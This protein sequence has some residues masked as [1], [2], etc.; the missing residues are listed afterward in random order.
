MIG[1]GG[2]VL[3]QHGKLMVIW[4]YY[5]VEMVCVWGGACECVHAHMC[6]LVC[7]CVRAC[8]CEA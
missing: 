6:V 3:H 8:L 2:G 5:K 1:G 4:Q 7:A